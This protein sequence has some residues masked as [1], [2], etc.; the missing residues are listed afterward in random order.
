MRRAGLGGIAALFLLGAVRPATAATTVQS[1]NTGTQ[2]WTQAGNPYVVSGDITVEAG[3]TLTIQAGTVVQFAPSD[4]TDSGIST[5]FIELTVEGSL[6]VKGTPATPVTFDSP[7]ATTPEGW[8]GIVVGASDA[9]VDITGAVIQRA[10][11][12]VVTSSTAPGTVTVKQSLI[13]NGISGLSLVDGTVSE[14]RVTGMVIAGIEVSG[15]ATITNAIVDHN[16]YEGIAIAAYSSTPVVTIQNC[17]ID[18]NQTGVWVETPGITATI[19]DTL[20]TN[21]SQYGIA[22][23]ATSVTNVSY[24]EFWH[25]SLG[26]YSNL[27]VGPGT[28][29]ADP[30]YVGAMDYHLQGG[31]PAI[32]TGTSSGA[33]D[34]DFDLRARPLD[35]DG[36]NGA[37]VDLGAYEAPLG[38]AGGS[39]GGSGGAAAGGN[40][41]GSGAGGKAGSSGGAAGAGSGAAGSAGHGGA[42]GGSAGGSA[43][44][45]ATGARGGAGGAAAAGTGGAAGRAAA[46]RG[47]PVFPEAG[48]PVARGWLAERPAP[49]P[50]VTAAQAAAARARERRGMTRA[51]TDRRRAAARADAAAR[52]G[53]ASQGRSRSGSSR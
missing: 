12:G 5:P 38:G 37:A 26:N 35:G 52:P 40:G 44:G 17:T 10:G 6:S 46:P 33:P 23:D 31:S 8:Y 50:A 19:V 51:P 29:T 7:D 13:E 14:V 25:N 32:D 27:T 34:H 11:F 18:G 49:T 41:G 48:R 45:G 28:V 42:A 53:S 21:S 36:L 20:I 39:G 43:G 47:A 30:R 15:K 9:V 4:A 1:G 22:H 24:T 3:A 2:T 16:G